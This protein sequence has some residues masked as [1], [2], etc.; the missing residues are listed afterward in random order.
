MND[1]IRKL[2]KQNVRF[3]VIGG[4]AMQLIGMP[5]M[6]IDWDLFIPPRDLE[7]F[8]MLNA[9]LE[10][11]RDIEVVP[12]GPNGEHFIQTFQTQWAILQFIW[13]S[14]EFRPMKRPND[15]RL[16]LPTTT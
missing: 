12:L 9:A 13:A 16:R 4:H 10:E 14:L 8:R 2:A 1:A 11:E 6:T 3:V 15:W 7:N 5:R